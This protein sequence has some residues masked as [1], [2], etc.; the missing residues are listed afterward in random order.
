MLRDILLREV[1]VVLRTGLYA[2]P[3]LIGATVL[4]LA[5]RTGIHSVTVPIIAASTCFAIRL[6]G[7]HFDIEIP[8]PRGTTHPRANAPESTSDRL[9]DPPAGPNAQ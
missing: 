9:T 3:A 2:I 7:I 5:S 6:V 1:P 4:V 8:K